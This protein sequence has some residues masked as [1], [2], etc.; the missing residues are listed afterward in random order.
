MSGN[1]GDREKKINDTYFYQA[2][3]QNKRIDP[4]PYLVHS[5][6]SVG[7]KGLGSGRWRLGWS[8][9]LA[10]FHLV[11]DWSVTDDMVCAG[12]LTHQNPH[13]RGH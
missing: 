1:A 13:F 6:K 5:S 10:D 12:I 7:T 11:A 2:R 9:A 8:S 3:S 4:W